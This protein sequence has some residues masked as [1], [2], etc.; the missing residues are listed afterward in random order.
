MLAVI[1]PCPQTVL[2]TIYKAAKAKFEGE[3][4]NKS[5]KIN[6]LAHPGPDLLVH[7]HPSTLSCEHL[8]S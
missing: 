6:I 3:C 2:V 8:I 1:L 7:E 5:D 4:F